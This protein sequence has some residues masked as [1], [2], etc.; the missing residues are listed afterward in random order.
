[1][2]YNKLFYLSRDESVNR[3]DERRNSPVG[4]N[5]RGIDAAWRRQCA[6]VVGAQSLQI[7]LDQCRWQLT[8]DARKVK[9]VAEED[10]SGE[11][12][13]SSASNPIV[14]NALDRAVRSVGPG[15][16]EVSFGVTDVN[17]VESPRPVLQ[18]AVDQTEEAVVQTWQPQAL[19]KATGQAVLW[20]IQS[21][22]A[23]LNVCRWQL[24][25][26]KADGISSGEDGAEVKIFSSSSEEG[27]NCVESSRVN[28]STNEALSDSE[29][30]KDE[31][32][33]LNGPP[34]SACLFQTRSFACLPSTALCTVREA[35][36]SGQYFF[37][38]T[39][40]LSH[41]KAGSVNIARHC[42]GPKSLV[43]VRQNET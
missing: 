8:A 35:T 28:V 4:A 5:Y 2:S 21:V 32:C 18:A 31:C 16:G 14:A 41:F 40:Y 42:E 12:T 36:P 7:M 3:L 20:G 26:D 24:T 10:D 38:T 1:L 23:M 19:R 22:E 6:V 33:A 15:I 11:I 27:K 30:P 39:C 9:T 43:Q 25:A 13:A 29:F 34:S 37:Y 17:L